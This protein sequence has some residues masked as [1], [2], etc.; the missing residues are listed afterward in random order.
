MDHLLRRV[1]RKPN[2]HT[3]KSEIIARKTRKLFSLQFLGSLSRTKRSIERPSPFFHHP[4]RRGHYAQQTR[5]HPFGIPRTQ[6]DPDR[7]LRIPSLIPRGFSRGGTYH[8]GRFRICPPRHRRCRQDR[9]TD[10][11]HIGSLLRRLRVLRLPGVVRSHGAV[12][13][14]RISGRSSTG[15]S[16]PDLCS[17]LP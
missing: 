7:G 10:R 15:C 11:H 13:D 12:R 2:P 1:G 17:R 4:L 6:G 5:R 14:E 9:G 8:R 3:Y 16:W